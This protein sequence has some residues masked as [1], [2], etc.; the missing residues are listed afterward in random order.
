L[1]GNLRE[2]EEKK[3]QKEIQKEEPKPKEVN[4]E[5]I[6]EIKQEQLNPHF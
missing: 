4:T 3:K 5:S 1:F 2:Q 6:P